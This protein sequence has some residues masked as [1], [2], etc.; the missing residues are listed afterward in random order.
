MNRD[1]LTLLEL[2]LALVLLSLLYASVSSLVVEVHAL[3]RALEEPREQG[4]GIDVPPLWETLSLEDLNKGEVLYTRLGSGEA[5][6][7]T[8]VR[9]A[10]DDLK[11]AG[12]LVEIQT[13]N[14]STFR[15]RVV[16]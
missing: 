14:V 2:V 12:T 16:N 9:W 15:Y 11:P 7:G 5:V 13:G 10:S 1:G 6:M 4:F 3:G 8:P